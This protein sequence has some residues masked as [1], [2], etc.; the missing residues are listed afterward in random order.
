MSYSMIIGFFIFILLY[1]V[2]L[3]YVSYNGLVWLR[4][5]FDFKYKKSYI[6][7]MIIIQTFF[8]IGMIYQSSI[9]IYLGG[10][11]LIIFC[12]SILLFPFANIIVFATKKKA[13]VPLGCVLIGLYVLLLAIGSYN[14]WN[15]VVKSFDIVVEKE[16]DRK[17]LKIL[18]APDI[19]LSPTVGRS[20][21]QKLVDISVKEKPDIILLPG[22]LVNDDITFYLKENMGE[23]MQKLQAPLGTYAVLGNHEY[24]GHQVKEIVDTLEKDG[25]QFL[26]DESVLIED[27]FYLVGRKDYSDAD[28]KLINELVEEIDHSKPI[29]VMDHQPYELNDMRKSGIDMSFSGHTHRG[30]VY[31]GEWI[32]NMLFEV[33]YGHVEK[34]DLHTFVSSGFGNWG[35]PFRIGTRSEVFIIN[36]KFQH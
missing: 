33:D 17:D 36:V 23:V 14:A 6:T 2:L 35:P 30:Q 16:A 25:V 15:P 31:P 1:T 18:M 20:H 11:W 34:E 19:H 12:Y 22:D 13:I 29:L 8:F 32:T 26:L 7:F 4:K 27:S 3:F 21:L 10:A 28:R 24:Y 9:L 5:A